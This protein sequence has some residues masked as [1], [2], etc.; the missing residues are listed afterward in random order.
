MGEKNDSRMIPTCLEIKFKDEFQVKDIS[1]FG[2]DCYQLEQEYSILERAG[3][4][5]FNVILYNDKRNKERKNTTNIFDY[6][7]QSRD[8]QWKY[9]RV[10]RL[11]KY[12]KYFIFN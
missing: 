11:I 2:I 5:I 6:L 7:E 9:A 10:S 4:K 12:E 8:L 3:M 1:Y